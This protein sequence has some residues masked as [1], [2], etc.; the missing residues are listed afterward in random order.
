MGN[1]QTQLTH[2]MRCGGVALSVD[3]MAVITVIS[4]FDM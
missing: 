1:K 4:G 2:Y 3:P